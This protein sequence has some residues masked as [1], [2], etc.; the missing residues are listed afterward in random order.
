MVN[1]K[2]FDVKLI[3]DVCKEGVFLLCWIIFGVVGL[4][5][6]LLGCVMLM[7]LGGIDSLVVGYLV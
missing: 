5:V 6:G 3:I 1:V 4:L 7:F 2:N